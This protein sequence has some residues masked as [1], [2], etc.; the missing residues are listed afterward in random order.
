[1][2]G[3]TAPVR[4]RLHVGA[5]ATRQDDQLLVE[6]EPHR[7]VAVLERR[8]QHRVVTVVDER[9]RPPE[10]AR[11]D[12]EAGQGAGQRPE[13]RRHLRIGAAQPGDDPVV[14]AAVA[15]VVDRQL[16]ADRP[17]LPIRDD[18]LDV[19]VDRHE[20]PVHVVDDGAG[21]FALL[22]VQLVH[23]AAPQVGHP[24]AELRALHQTGR[25][26][27]HDRGRGV[28]L[29]RHP[30]RLVRRPPLEAQ[31]LQKVIHYSS[32]P[33]SPMPWRPNIER[34]S[35]SPPC[36]ERMPESSVLR[37]ACRSSSPSPLNMRAST[38]WTS[39]SQG[40]SR[41]LPLAVSRACRIRPWSGWAR[42]R[43]S[44]LSSS[45]SS[46]SFI[47]WGDTSARR[48]SWALERP[49][50]RLSTLSVVYWLT[51]SPCAFRTVPIARRTTRSM[52]PT[53]YNSVGS[54]P[55]SVISAMLAAGSGAVED[56]VEGRC[57]LAESIAEITDDGG[58]HKEGR[59]PI[60]TTAT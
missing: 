6:L 29:D 31:H 20:R 9:Q 48:A 38:A 56:N 32:S 19:V 57:Q 44:P 5:A 54:P 21:A 45:V 18:L 49:L 10:P 41:A 28:G 47:D 33:R 58:G 17:H 34:Y 53:R 52:R 14:V 43:T 39:A 2:C 7:V 23:A 35:R 55:S 46:T 40:A 12:V 27:L 26:E 51:D 8:R 13:R 59:T 50:R 30:E 16:A 22:R 4:S 1:M 25:L 60:C 24:I 37:R 3:R 36:S 15:V 11:V 42:R